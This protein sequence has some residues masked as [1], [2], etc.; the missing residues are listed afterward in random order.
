MDQ[1]QEA[2]ASVVRLAVLCHVAQLLQPSCDVDALSVDSETALTIGVVCADDPD[3]ILASFN[4]P[5]TCDEGLQIVQDAGGDCNTDAH[6]LEAAIP[7]GTLARYICPAHCGDC[8]PGDTDG[9]RA[10]LG[11]AGALALGGHTALTEWGLHFDGDHDFAMLRTGAYGAD[12]T[13]SY[14]LWFSKAECNPRAATH[15]EYMIAH[16]AA[17]DS[18]RKLERNGPGSDPNVHIY[19]GCRSPQ[20]FGPNSFGAS[21]V[22]LIQELGPPSNFPYHHGRQRWFVDPVDLP[23][24]ATLEEYTM[25]GWN[26][27]AFDVTQRVHCNFRWRSDPR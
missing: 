18:D 2:P 13:W 9:A 12:T 20:E 23:L 14:S 1:R 27:I 11:R 24:S 16:S 22:L 19:L 21:R 25:G 3:G 5:V 15:W 10:A 8:V 17:E 6:D 4:P 26:H 7:E